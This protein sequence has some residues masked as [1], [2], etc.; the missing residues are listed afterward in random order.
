MLD[1][2][3]KL[4]ENMVFAGTE[5]GIAIV[6]ELAAG[7]LKLKPGMSLRDFTRILDQYIDK[8]KAQIVNNSS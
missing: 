6:Q 4:S 7:T 8:A 2:K 3:I 5:L 1:P